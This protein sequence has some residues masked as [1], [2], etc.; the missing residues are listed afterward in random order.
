MLLACFLVKNKLAEVN[1]CSATHLL[2]HAEM[3]FPTLV[4]HRVVG[5]GGASRHGFIRYINGVFA[6]LWHVGHPFG[7]ALLPLLYR[8]HAAKR[9]IA[10]GVLKVGVHLMAVGKAFT[11][12]LLPCLLAVAL[13]IYSVWRQCVGIVVYHHFI[14]IPISF[15]RHKHVCARVFEHGHEERQHVTLRVEVFYGLQ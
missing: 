1:P 9:T 5:R 14:R 3:T 6:S 8:L 11:L 2:V 4:M 12:S 13:F 7:K 10:E 15:A